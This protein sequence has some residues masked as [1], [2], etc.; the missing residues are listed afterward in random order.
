MLAKSRE[1]NFGG[2]ATSLWGRSFCFDLIRRMEKGRR[3]V[4]GGFLGVTPCKWICVVDEVFG[5]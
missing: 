3:I 4:V 2:C 5:Y 1:L